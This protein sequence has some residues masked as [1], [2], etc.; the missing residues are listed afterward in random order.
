[1]KSV[2]WEHCFS[3]AQVQNKLLTLFVWK[4]LEGPFTP[5]CVIRYLLAYIKIKNKAKE[6]KGATQQH[7]LVIM[8]CYS[9]HYV[10]VTFFD[11]V[12]GHS[13][14]VCPDVIRTNY[15]HFAAMV[16]LLFLHLP[17]YVHCG[18]QTCFLQNITL[19]V[20][21]LLCSVF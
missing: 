18:L 8:P 16:Y 2:F 20:T 12:L 10:N 19:T 17:F 9:I 7:S 14:P 1:M 21:H 13:A 11:K 15:L 6:K 4:Q 3:S 5:W